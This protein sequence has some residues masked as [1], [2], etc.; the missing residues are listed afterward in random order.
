MENP[1]I[2]GVEYQRGTLFEAEMWEYLLEKFGRKCYYC[3]AKD[4]PLEKEHILPRSKGGTNRVSNL[5]VSCK[6]CNQKKGNKHP[7]EIQG[8][9]GK[10]V[11]KALKDAEKTIKEKVLKHAQAVNIIRWKIVESLKATGLPITYGTGGKTK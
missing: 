7:N 2:S 6:S 4:V 8:E 9:L 3:G 11:Q 1:E 5:T 10:R